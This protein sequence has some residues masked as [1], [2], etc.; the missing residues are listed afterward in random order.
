MLSAEPPGVGIRKGGCSSVVLD[1]KMTADGKVWLGQNV[2]DAGEL[3]KFGV[4]II[5]HPANAPPMVTWALAGGLGAIGMNRCGLALLMNYV[6]AVAGRVENAIFPEFVAHAA[7]RQTVFKE[8]MGVLMETQIMTSATF[9]A[10]SQ[11]GDRVAIERTPSR[12]AAWT[13]PREYLAY[14]NH[15]I[16]EKMAASDM[17]DKAFPDSKARLKR[18]DAL[19]NKKKD[20]ETPEFL[21]KVLSD[22]EGNPNGICRRA[23]PR[24]IA[25]VVMCPRDG[26]MFVT[27]GAPD[28]VKYREV[29]LTAKPE[30][31]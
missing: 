28:A 21:E 20:V 3:E 18:L 25:S 14:T 9:I 27:K 24:T 2:D 12:Y 6:Q 4:V 5:R 13:P 8:M 11:D 15:M 16:D 1:K 26:K 19:L 10:A 30:L 17:T 29:Q 22:V 23:E 7:L 31:E